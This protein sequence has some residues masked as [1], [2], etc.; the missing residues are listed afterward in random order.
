MALDSSQNNNII[1]LYRTNQKDRYER[2]RLGAAVDIAP[3]TL[4]E[5]EIKSIV[6]FLHALTGTESIKGRLGRPNRVP[7]GLE[8]D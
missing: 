3:V 6:A 4:T 8:V 2:A 5:T 7:S 1:A